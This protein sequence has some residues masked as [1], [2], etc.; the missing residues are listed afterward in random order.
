MG[1]T[2]DKLRLHA[3]A[4]KTFY[5]PPF[6][7]SAAVKLTQTGRRRTV[8]RA[9]VVSVHEGTPLFSGSTTT[10]KRWA[11]P[12]IVPPGAPQREWDAERGRG[13]CGRLQSGTIALTPDSAAPLGWIL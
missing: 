6:A 4:A 2:L 10:V 1:T 12:G 8:Q 3:A 13:G 9:F 5:I 11:R 7:T